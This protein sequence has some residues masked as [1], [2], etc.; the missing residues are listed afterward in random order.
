MTG[1]S[2]RASRIG[3]DDAEAIRAVIFRHAQCLDDGRFDDLPALY[4]EDAEL[5]TAAKSWTGAR[6]IVK[7]L[8]KAQPPERRGKHCCVN[9]VIDVHDD[10]TTVAATDYVFIGPDKTVSAFGRYVDTMLEVDG[11][12]LIRQRRIEA[13]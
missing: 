4:T 13:G 2:S 3:A 9:T 7:V 8:T 10:G 5:A 1:G 6:V 11:A 12:W